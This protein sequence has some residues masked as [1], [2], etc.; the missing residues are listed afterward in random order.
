MSTK[1]SSE[2]VS[3]GRIVSRISPKSPAHYYE[4]HIDTTNNKP[5]ILKGEEK[6]WKKEPHKQQRKQP[7]H[8]F[9]K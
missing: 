7:P 4:L 5:E 9:L 6:E 3:S 8:H 1:P 2:T